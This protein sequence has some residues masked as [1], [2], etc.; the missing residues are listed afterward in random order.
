MSENQ[1]NALRQDF[2]LFL[3][4][5]H[6][7]KLGEG[8]IKFDK[9]FF[10]GGSNLVSASSRGLQRSWPYVGPI[11]HPPKKEP[12]RGSRSMQDS[13]CIKLHGQVGGSLMSTLPVLNGCG[14]KPSV[15]EILCKR[16]PHIAYGFADIPPSCLRVHSMPHNLW[17][18]ACTP[19]A[20][21]LRL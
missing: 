5:S 9:M 16:L 14:C 12:G 13:S 20:A 8:A 19:G 11:F 10:L 18:N 15:A 1:G 6:G 21:S 17:K 2:A 4:F 3:T 7:A